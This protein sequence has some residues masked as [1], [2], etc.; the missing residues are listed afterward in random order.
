MTLQE[1]IEDILNFSEISHI[2]SGPVILVI[3]LF[4]TFFNL[5]TLFILTIKL[6]GKKALSTAL[7]FRVAA[8]AMPIVNAKRSSIPS[9]P[10]KFSTPVSIR[11]F[12][13]YDSVRRFSFPGIEYKFQNKSKPRIYIYFLWLICCDTALLICSLLLYS[14]PIVFDCL[15][16]PY[17]TLIPFW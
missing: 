4:G 6:T 7:V 11:R 5:S 12:S 15:H 3:V 2:L 8:T 13:I 1:P 10:R 16:G 17:A 9:K 14:V